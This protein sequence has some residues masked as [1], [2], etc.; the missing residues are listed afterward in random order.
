VPIAESTVH[1][2]ATDYFAAHAP[3]WQASTVELADGLYKSWVMPKWGET[4]ASTITKADVITWMASGR[5]LKAPRRAD[6]A[7]SLLR[8]ILGHAAD[9]MPPKLA[10]NVALGVKPPKA[11]QA[12]H[13]TF[14]PA[15]ADAL[16]AACNTARDRVLV[17]LGLH[18]G[19]RIGEARGLRWCD[20]ALDENRI[21]IDRAVWQGK[22]QE[23]HV[24]EPKS[25][26][27]RRVF[28]TPALSAALAELRALEAEKPGFAVTDYVLGGRKGQPMARKSGYQALQ[29]IAD[30]A[31]VKDAAGKVLTGTHRLRRTSAS[32]ALHDG[33]PLPVVSAQLGHANTRITAQA[34]SH[35]LE[36]A[37]LDAYGA[38]FG[39]ESVRETVR[40]KRTPE[41]AGSTKR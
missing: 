22:G 16:V 9:A 18:G 36:D 24:K 38:A 30:R 2:L 23:R 4:V 32:L 27:R 15:Q 19:L 11:K 34:Y 39:A 26:R 12:A 25:E 5:A 6:Q 17:L 14:T 29:R 31:G 3:S 28:V 20:L 1:E 35:V 21:R 13:A 33:V 10:Q 7:L 40:G 8:R 41:K 37:Q